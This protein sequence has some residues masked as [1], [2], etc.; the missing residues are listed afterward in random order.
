MTHICSKLGFEGGG[1]KS[2][3]GGRVGVGQEIGSLASLVLVG[4]RERA[5]LR[6]GYSSILLGD[7]RR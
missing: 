2:G 3:A 4:E 7:A 1:A 6:C 5:I